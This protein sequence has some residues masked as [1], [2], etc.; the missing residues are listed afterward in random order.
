MHY[1]NKNTYFDIRYITLL[2]MLVLHIYSQTSSRFYVIV[3]F[4]FYHLHIREDVLFT[5]ISENP[6][7]NNETRIVVKDEE[8]TREL[9]FVSAVRRDYSASLQCSK[10]KILNMNISS[11]TTLI[12]YELRRIEDRRE[13]RSQVQ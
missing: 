9:Y 5:K 8:G 11:G 3:T 12:P 13:S 7:L 2:L 10:A 6:S 1:K 4:S